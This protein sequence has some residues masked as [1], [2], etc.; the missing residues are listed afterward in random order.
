[1]TN[2]LRTIAIVEDNDDHA[3]LMMRTFEKQKASVRVRRL[4]DGEDALNY[5]LRRDPYGDEEAHPLPDLLL[6]DLRLPKVDGLEVL[7]TVKESELLRHVPVVILST[8]EAEADVARAYQHHANAYLV[9]PF[10]LVDFREMLADLG[11]FW[12]VWNRQALPNQGAA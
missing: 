6:L 1:M 4:T 10:G 7:R 11:V 12:L 5:L 2:R 3:E 8:S 9:K